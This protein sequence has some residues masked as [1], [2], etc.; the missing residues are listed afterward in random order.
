MPLT[1]VEGLVS[2]RELHARLQRRVEYPQ[3]I[4]MQQIRGVLAASDFRMAAM[5]SDRAYGPRALVD[6]L[7]KPEVASRIVSSIRT[8]W[9]SKLTPAEQER[10]SEEL[11]ALGGP[12]P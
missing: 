7:V 9:N 8:Q 10:L 1:L 6:H 11:E 3:W 12:K 5:E 4:C 2:C